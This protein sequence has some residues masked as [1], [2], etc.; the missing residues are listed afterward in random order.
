MAG[1]DGIYNNLDRVSVTMR[2]PS[3]ET[4]KFTGGVYSLQVQAGTAGRYWRQSWLSGGGDCSPRCGG[5]G[6]DCGGDCSPRC[7]GRGGDCQMVV[8]VVLGVV[9]VVVRWWSQWR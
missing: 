3:S 1:R 5:R 2:P 6:G 7:G 8:F 4:E 9:V